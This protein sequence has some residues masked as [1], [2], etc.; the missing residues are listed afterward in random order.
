MAIINIQVH[1][2]QT[3]LDVAIQHLGDATGALELAVLNNL[4]L[5]AEL[6]AGQVLQVDTNQIVNAKVVNYLKQKDVIPI[7]D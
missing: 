1:D 3:L 2:R 4:S 7:T 5:T 6:Q